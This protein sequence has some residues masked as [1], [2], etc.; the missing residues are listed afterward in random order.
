MRRDALVGAARL[1]EAVNR[2]GLEHQPGAC[3]TV[4]QF[5]VKPNSRNTIPGQVAFTVDLRHPEADR[6]AAMKGALEAAVAEICEA[7][8]LTREVE[9][10]WYQPPLRFDAACVEA[11][12]RGAAASEFGAMDIVSGAGHDACHVAALAPT[13]M[14]LQVRRR[15]GATARVQVCQP[16][17][18][19]T[20]VAPNSAS[21][22]SL[23]GRRK[24]RWAQP[25][26]HRRATR[27]GR[28]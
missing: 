7:I 14:S 28:G 23:S 27:A 8:G 1:V 13:A 3:A 25:R 2:I 4:G 24:K 10:I 11:V 9:E 17:L 5:D 6:L 21:R 18:G 19:A 16:E 15:Q 22:S 20:T 26:P 12:R